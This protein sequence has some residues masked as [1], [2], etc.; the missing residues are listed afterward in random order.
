MGYSGGHRW[1]PKS[2]D[3]L[4]DLRRLGFTQKEISEQLGISFSAV[5]QACKRYRITAPKREKPE[6]AKVRGVVIDKAEDGELREALSARGYRVEKLTP[7]KMDRRFK[8]D[9]RLFDGEVIK[10]GS[11]SCTHLGSKYQQLTH[12]HSFYQYAQEQGCKVIF[13]NGDMVDGINVYPGHEYE[14]F[15]HGIKAQR[16]YAIRHYP[17]MENGGKT[18]VIDGNHDYSFHKEIG[19]DI[20]EGVA[21]KREDIEYLGSYGA[22]PKVLGLNIYM[23]HGGGMSKPYARS[24]RMQKN[25]EEMTPD[26]KPDFYFLGHYH[27]SCILLEYRNVIAFQLPSFQAQTPYARRSGW[28]AEV[29]GFIITV[30][31]NER[32]RASGGTSKM[33]FEFVP[34]Y[35][36]KENDF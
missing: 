21:S 7:D 33:Q 2:I 35:V 29:G 3:R 23:H 32:E 14:L 15:L 1:T 9:P 27:A 10:F 4:K 6:E 5:E 20:L 18:Y 24:Y 19:D 25:I 13:H 8:I 17:R 22:F 26:K 16:E 11:I 31:K 34:F 28:P 30:V 12:L 36:P